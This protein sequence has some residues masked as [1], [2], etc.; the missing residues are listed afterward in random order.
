MTI[1]AVTKVE[2]A[3][4]AMALAAWSWLDTEIRDSI[5]ERLTTFHSLRLETH[6]VSGKPMDSP[7][8]HAH[9]G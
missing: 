7:N 4:V 8:H 5:D 1:P 3:Q 2:F 9:D 6:R